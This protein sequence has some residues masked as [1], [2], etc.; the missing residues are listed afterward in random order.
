[1]EYK[2]KKLI[3]FKRRAI[4]N[5][6]VILTTLGFI[7]LT[8]YA[9]VYAYF[10][11][12]LQITQTI[13]QFHPFWFD[14]LMK[15]ISFIGNFSTGIIIVIAVFLAFIYFDRIKDAS[16]FLLSAAGATAIADIF[17][18]LVARPRPDAHLITQIGAFTK[19]DSFPSGHVLHFVGVY[20]FLLYLSLRYLKGSKKI[21]AVSFFIV[22]ISLIGLSRIYLGAHWFSDTIGAYL[23]GVTWLLFIIYF[24]PKVKLWNNP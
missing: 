18:V 3:S 24:Y 2:E 4:L 8:V 19:A 7:L 12:D 20:G 5:S 17:K 14:S 16:F 10:P 11:F 22:L 15:T 1:M 21:M 13:Q 9:R 23:I 6:I